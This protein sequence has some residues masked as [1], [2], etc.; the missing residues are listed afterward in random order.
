MTGCKQQMHQSAQLA[1]KHCHSAGARRVIRPA[2]GSTG[3]SL[4]EAL[5]AAAVLS[6]G[7]LGA[8]SMVMSAAVLDKRAHHLTHASLIFEEILEN[9]LRMQHD[10]AQYRNMTAPSG[11]VTMDGIPYEVTCSLA[12]D[13][14]IATCTEMTCS[15]SWNTNG[16]RTKTSHAYTFSPK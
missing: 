16:R 1:Q 11:M 13:A 3:F 2:P 8:V 9:M 14:P 6:I 12:A 10:P 4:V 5:I 15:I 7:I